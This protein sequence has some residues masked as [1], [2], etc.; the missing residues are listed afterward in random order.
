MLGSIYWE[1]GESLE[2]AAQR[3]G[4]LIPVGIQS[5]AGWGLSNLE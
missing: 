4:C 2:Q 1:G 5:Q 3:C